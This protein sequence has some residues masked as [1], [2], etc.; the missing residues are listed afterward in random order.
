[1]SG[2]SPK[3]KP[4]VSN[5]LLFGRC[6]GTAAPK[7]AHKGRVLIKL[8]EMLMRIVVRAPYS[9]GSIARR[10]SFDAVRRNTRSGRRG[11]ASKFSVSQCEPGWRPTIH[12]RGIDITSTK[13]SAQVRSAANPDRAR[14]TLQP[15][16]LPIDRLASL[17]RAVAGSQHPT[18]ASSTAILG[19]LNP[20]TPQPL[21]WPSPRQL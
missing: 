18:R 11:R 6:H 4:C 13:P 3:G 21:L 15:S 2:R 20:L 1:M 8:C 9:C 14:H 17:P 19:G 12:R 7:N 10:I 5:F 16:A